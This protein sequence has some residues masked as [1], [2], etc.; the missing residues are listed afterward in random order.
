MPTT[1][2]MELARSGEGMRCWIWERWTAG[3]GRVTFLVCAPGGRASQPGMDLEGETWDFCVRQPG[4]VAVTS[5]ALL[6][7]PR[8]HVP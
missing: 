5:G 4:I 3:A 1:L 2:P 7:T 8:A 6:L